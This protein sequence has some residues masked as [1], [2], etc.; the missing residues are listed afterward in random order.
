MT[1]EEERMLRETV[2]LTR[3]TNVLVKKIQKGLMWARVVKVIYWVILIGVTVGAFYFVQ[4]YID[5]FRE[6]YAGF[7]NSQEGL[8]T[9]FGF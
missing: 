4:P 6:L 3:E 1:P 7:A 5:G 2:Q 8:K 9:L